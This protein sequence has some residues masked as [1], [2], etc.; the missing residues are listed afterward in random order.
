M[1]SPFVMKQ[2]DQLEGCVKFT[3]VCFATTGPTS[4]GEQ[5]WMMSRPT[6]ITYAG[7][8]NFESRMTQNQEGENDE[9]MDI[10]YLVKV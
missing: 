1:N 5:G 10:N 9:Y 2:Y 8:I 3:F 4:K 7:T 6:T